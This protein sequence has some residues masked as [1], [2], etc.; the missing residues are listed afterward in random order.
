MKKLIVSIIMLF[1]TPALAGDTTISH[2]TKISN[3]VIVGTKVSSIVSKEKMNG[4][5]LRV[6][7]LKVKVD[8]V[9]YGKVGEKEI[10]VVL[11]EVGTQVAQVFPEK[12]II[13]FIDFPEEYFKYLP[14]SWR[15]DK[16]Y[17]APPFGVL[18]YEQNRYKQVKSF[19]RLEDKRI[20]WAKR[21]LRANDPVLS[22]SAAASL[23]GVWRDDVADALND[24]MT[25]T[26]KE[27]RYDHQ[28]LEEVLRNV[29]SSRAKDHLI[30]YHMHTP[31]IM[32]NERAGVAGTQWEV[33]QEGVWMKMSFVPG[34]KKHHVKAMGR[35]DKA[36]FLGLVDAVNE[37][38]LKLPETIG[39][40]PEVNGQ[41]I[42]I[43]F[44]GKKVVL[45][46]KVLSSL[47]TADNSLTN[48]LVNQMPKGGKEGQN[49]ARFIRIVDDIEVTLQEKK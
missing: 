34:E 49:W 23:T 32:R 24:A 6:I 47:E 21:N 7:R 4:G 41:T 42:T 36:I 10:S 33:S 30:K 1:A 12:L 48:Q 43:E 37:D 26:K 3:C 13:F 8:R 17:L 11:G 28:L 9:L 45:Y 16:L 27:D 40:L 2:M 31:L 25:S 44:N 15:Q 19:L 5:E 20:K 35:L 22:S 29:Y 38:W 39:K 18:A 14:K 46:G